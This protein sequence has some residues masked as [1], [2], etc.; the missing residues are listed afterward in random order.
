MII[1]ASGSPEHSYGFG[2][3]IRFREPYWR[4]HGIGFGYVRIHHVLAT[5]VN[6]Q[7]SDLIDRGRCHTKQWMRFREDLQQVLYIRL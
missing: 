1:G 4:I 7:A 2:D 6:K 3:A 5:L